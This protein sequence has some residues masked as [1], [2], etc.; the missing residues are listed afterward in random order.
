FKRASRASELRRLHAKYP[1]LDT[2]YL[3][4]LFARHGLKAHVILKEAQTMEEL[5]IDFGGGLMQREVE[6]LA[7]HEWAHNAE[8]ILWRRTKC[9]LHMSAEQQAA[10]TEY[11]TASKY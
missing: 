6:Y 11:F 8:D 9:G 10:F 1:Q 7:L 2:K 4:K 5:G 3:D